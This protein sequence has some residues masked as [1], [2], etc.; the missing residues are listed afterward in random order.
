MAQADAEHAQA[1]TVDLASEPEWI[2]LRSRL[3]RALKPFPKARL[4]AAAALGL[5]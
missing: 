3:L 1:P 5:D 4:A 2:A